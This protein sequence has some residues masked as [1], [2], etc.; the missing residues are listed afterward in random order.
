MS[1][2]IGKEETGGTLNY[3]SAEHEHTIVEI[4]GEDAVLIGQSKVGGNSFWW[5]KIHMTSI[6]EVDSEK[7]EWHLVHNEVRDFDVEKRR[8]KV[9]WGEKMTWLSTKKKL[10]QSLEVLLK[11]KDLD[12]I[13]VREIVLKA[14]VS[15][16]TFYRNF[17]DKYDLAEY[18]FYLLFANTFERIL[19]GADWESSLFRYLEGFEQKADILRRAYLSTN[20]NSFRNYNIQIT[21]D[22]YGQYLLMKGVDIDAAEMKFAIEVAAWGSMNMVINWLLN[23]MKEDKMLLVKLIKRTLPMDLLAYL[24]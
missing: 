24:Q 9:E 17:K 7:E 22:T 5:R 3:F 19:L 12:H 4:T 14:G 13:S 15:R 2:K 18:A 8:C 6:T 11:S 1:A 10:V 20:T 23:G 16:K 21:I